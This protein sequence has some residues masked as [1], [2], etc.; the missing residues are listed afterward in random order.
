MEKRLCMSEENCRNNHETEE[1]RK[2]AEE[3]NI[4]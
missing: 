2:I 3:K 1:D 4:N